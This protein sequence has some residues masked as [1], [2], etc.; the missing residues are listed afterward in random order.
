MER[1][2]PFTQLQLLSSTSPITASSL[3]GTLLYTS[4]NTSLSIT[5]LTTSTLSSTSIL[6]SGSSVSKILPLPSSDT[7]LLLIGT[8]LRDIDGVVVATGVVD[9]VVDEVV[10]SGRVAVAKRRGVS[11]W[12]A[13]WKG[14]V[15]VEGV[16]CMSLVGDILCIAGKCSSITIVDYEM[17]KI[18]KLGGKNNVVPLFPYDRLKGKPIITQVGQ[19]FLLV[20]SLSNDRGLGVFVNHFGDAVRGTLSYESIPSSIGILNNVINCF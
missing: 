6:S 16:V 20:T 7:V 17:Y 18:V 3:C 14:N 9:C 11:I 8:I 4:T 10:G 12:D 19:E 13:G 15:D 5:N 2:E 1:M